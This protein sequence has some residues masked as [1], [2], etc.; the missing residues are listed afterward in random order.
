[1]VYV[2]LCTIT[3]I[4]DFAISVIIFGISNIYSE[5]SRHHRQGHVYYIITVV[6][7]AN[8]IMNIVFNIKHPYQGQLYHVHH[9]QQQDNGTMGH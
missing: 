2:I 7:A 6:T 8:I 5:H 9:H 4:V 3:T 1:M